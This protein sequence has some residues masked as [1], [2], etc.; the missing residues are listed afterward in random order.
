VSTQVDP[1]PRQATVADTLRVAA[2][3]LGPTLAGGVIARRPAVFELA[4]RVEADRRALRRMQHL[5]ERYAPGPVRLRVPGRS[6]ALITSPEHVHRVLDGSPEPFA[7][8]NLEKRGALGHFQPHG[9]LVSRGPERTR[10]RAFNEAVLDTAH[11]VHR[12]AEPI[13]SVVVEEAEQLAAMAEVTGRL[14]SD[15]FV[16][17]WWRVIRRVVLGDA[18]R[19]DHRISDALTRLRREANWGYLAP[20]RERAYT[21]FKD[22]LSGYLDRAEPNSL[23]A[24]VAAT[25]T[26]PDTDPTDQVPQWLFAYDPAG[27]VILR[28]LALLATHPDAMARVTEELR[29]SSVPARLPQ[30][31]AS[32]LESARLWPTT[33]AV[34]R[35]TTEETEW[36]TGTLPAG[37]GLLIWAPLLHRDDRV[38]PY[39]HHYAPEIWLDERG[40]G[41]WPLIPFSE[42]PGVCPGQNLV[43]LTASTF[44]ATLLGRHNFE[45]EQD[46]VSPDRPLPLTF[47]P[48]R[49][50]FRLTRR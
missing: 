1:S 31:R 42:G 10:R 48:Y 45:L 29:D 27:L 24:A 17:A 6:F 18:A 39:A 50:S 49:L 38:L 32:V 41:D 13:T 26:A 15:Q 46:R 5:A 8:A 19:D 37:T 2:Q 34:L 4:D 21:E 43:L 14:D 33:P 40:H 7:L 35:D 47:S 22:R 11:P 30:L 36:P 3:V 23:A 28:A 25:P 9:V 44:L 12:M 20:R 16:Q